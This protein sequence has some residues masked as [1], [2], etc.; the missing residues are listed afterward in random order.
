MT[1]SAIPFD[2]IAAGMTVRVTDD[3]HM[4]AL[5]F[6][7]TLTANDRK[8]ASQ[9]LARVTTRQETAALLTLRHAAS[10]RKHARKMIS[11]SNAIQLLLLLPKRTV[12]IDTRRQVAG[13][14]AD[15][16]CCQERPKA[17][18]LSLDR[19]RL[20]MEL[21]ERC[22]PLSEDEMGRFRRAVAEHMADT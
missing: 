3:G 17:K 2:A 8:K 21:M 6:L 12:C 7:S 16:Y 14:L 18:R 22:G 15:H 1:H 13:V 19:I 4:L 5:D 10:G 9:T 20:C 11:F